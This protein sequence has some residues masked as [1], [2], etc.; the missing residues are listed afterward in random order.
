M[1][2]PELLSKQGTRVEHTW[3]SLDLTNEQLVHNTELWNRYV[4]L[5]RVCVCVIF[6]NSG[7]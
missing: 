2:F 3:L 5:W 7:D 6:Q 4:S 1:K